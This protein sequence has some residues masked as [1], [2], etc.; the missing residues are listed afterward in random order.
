[1]VG[2]RKKGKK[3]MGR[4]GREGDDNRKRIEAEK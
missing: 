2:I 4:G 3:G 1:M